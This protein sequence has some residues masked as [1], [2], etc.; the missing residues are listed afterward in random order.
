M[1]CANSEV[2]QSGE[3]GDR[4]RKL[5]QAGRVSGIVRVKEG[6]T[7]KAGAAFKPADRNIF[8]FLY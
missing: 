7:W 8:Q 2:G 3:V 5:E 6:G 1:F 4:E